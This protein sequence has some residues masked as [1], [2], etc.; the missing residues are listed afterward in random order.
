MVWIQNILYGFLSGFTEFLP[1]SSQAHQMLFME[2]CGI[3]ANPVRD[4]CI[5]L[6]SLASLLIGCRTMLL[7]LQRDWSY[8]RAG[9]LRNRRGNTKAAYDIRLIRTAT[10][11]MV[12]ILLLRMISNSGIHALYMILFLIINGIILILP[13]YMRQA[14]K[15]ARSMSGL[16]GFLLGLAG[17]LS[18]LPGISRNGAIAALAVA[19]GADRKHAVDWA[20]MLSVPALIV[21]SGLDVFA[22][23][24]V[25]AGVI[26]FS[27]LL[28]YI[29]AT[30][31][32]FIGGYC[33]ILFVRFWAVR[34]DFSGFAYYSWGMALF[35]FVLY[36]I[37]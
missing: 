34:L 33:G 29:L 2:L 10:V 14:N 32:A 17:S 4:L 36:L 30:V 9:R 28:S 11:P 27:S 8:G 23:L 26:S 3:D 6:A 18:V 20:L 21:I 31:T 12:I 13:E 15:D 5:H 16:D 7:R 25:G 1:V 19:R 24:S 22:I 37:A 35:S